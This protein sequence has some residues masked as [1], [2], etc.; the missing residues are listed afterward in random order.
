V[1]AAR[2]VALVVDAHTRRAHRVL[3]LGAEELPAVLASPVLDVELAP[4]AEAERRLE[5]N[6]A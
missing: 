5:E 2:L 3:P 1:S 4:A 6:H